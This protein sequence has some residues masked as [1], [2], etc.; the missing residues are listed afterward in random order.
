MVHRNRTH[1][2]VAA[3]ALLASLIGAGAPAY[4]DEFRPIVPEP[5]NKQPD[6][7]LITTGA[8]MIGLP[9]L[10]G[11]GAAVSSSIPAD[12]YLYIPVAGPFVDIIVRA[13]CETSFCK[14]DIGTA[15][16]PLAISGLMQLGGVY[17][18]A[19]ALLS[20]GTPVPPKGA[21]VH[22]VPAAYAGGGGLAAF[23]RY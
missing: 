12:R 16:L 21:E 6:P 23:V 20:P 7:L 10:G 1:A 5:E 19:R 11:L 18:L 17:I 8:V 15:P 3:V 14:G 9:Y 2:R 4:A 13:T 22:V